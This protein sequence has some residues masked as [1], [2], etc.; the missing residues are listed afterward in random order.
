M[1]LIGLVPDGPARKWKP[2]F[3]GLVEAM[4]DGEYGRPGLAAWSA[5][6]DIRE[7]L[8][9]RTWVGGE[10]VESTPAWPPRPDRQLDPWA[11]LET[12]EAAKAVFDLFW[13]AQ[14]NWSDANAL[15][16]GLDLSEDEADHEVYVTRKLCPVAVLLTGL[17]YER[18]HRLPGTAGS[19]LLAA[20]EVKA[21]LADV[22]ELFDLT[23]AERET[24]LSTMGLWEQT[25]DAE[26][27]DL[28]TM[29]D[30]IPRLHRR[31]ADQ[32]TGILS[33]VT[34]PS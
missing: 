8:V 21:G 2:V 28:E 11:T 22:E 29:L 32:G 9:D 25:G 30:T 34:V 4:L 5:I 19:Y 18:S 15:L 1:W 33:L 10:V 7:H 17:G 26:K 31:A 13:T 20:D 27:L 6:G 3:D 16:N 14:I 12:D 23:A 24:V